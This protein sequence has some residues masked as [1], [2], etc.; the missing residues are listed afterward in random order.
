MRI[1]L[2]II[3]NLKMI[4]KNKIMMLFVLVMV[5]L[6]SGCDVPFMG[7]A[8]QSG[9]GSGSSDTGDKNNNKAVELTFNEGVPP[10]D[11][12]KGQEVTF[13]FMFKNYQEHDVTDMKLKVSGF[14]KSYVSNLNEMYTIS[15]IPRLTK[16]AGAGVLGSFAIR[17]VTVDKFQEEY[18]F[19]PVFD[20]CYKVETNFLE[21]ICVP[22]KKENKCNVEFKKTSMNNGPLK[23]NVNNIINKDNG[24]RIFFTIENRGD[25][26]AVNTCF[27][28]DYA[29]K[30]SVEAVLGT[31]KGNCQTSGDD[32]VVI[33][34]RSNFYCDFTRSQDTSY[35][36]QATVKLSYN[37]EQSVKKE[38]LVKSLE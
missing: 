7:D 16:E 17:D 22:D 28:K 3:K 14:D 33:N 27:E 23:L 20:Y 18:P 11:M 31:V 9:F 10:K 15:K 34:D 6:F 4:K 24:V 5:L 1:T 36:S 37:Y 8:K 2:N 26:K 35:S 29:T 12:Y 38:I 21:S 13:G 19:N 30:Y 25:G 32:F